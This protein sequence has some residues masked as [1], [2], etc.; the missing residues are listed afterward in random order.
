MPKTVAE[1][2]K[3]RC[4]PNCGGSPQRTSVKGPRPTFCKTLERDCKKEMNNRLIVE[5]RAVIG[6]LK[7]WRIDR[8]SGEIAT[9]SFAQAVETL[10]LFNAQDLKAGRPRAD[11]YAATLLGSGTR[12]F[13]R[14]RPPRAKKEKAGA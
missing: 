13:D 8:G 2:L 6:F 3:E 4:C 9:K 7:A 5:G 12:Y 10:D 1:R 14:Q 11:V